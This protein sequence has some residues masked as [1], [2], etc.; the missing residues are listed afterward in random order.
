MYRTMT[1]LLILLAPCP[2]LAQG[3]EI[4]PD[5]WQ[6]YEAR[7]ALLGDSVLGPLNLGVKVRNRVAVLWGPV[8]SVEI[9]NQA[10]SLL[11][12]L[13]GLVA[14]K[15][16]LDVDPDLLLPLYL[17]ETL[18]QSRRSPMKPGTPPPA[19]TLTNRSLDKTVAQEKPMAAAFPP[20]AVPP[21]TIPGMPDHRE[22]EMVLPSLRIPTAEPE[23]S[24]TPAEAIAELQKD[25][26]FAHIQ[27]SITAGIVTL[28]ADADQAPLLYEFA[29]R[30]SPIPGVARVVVQEK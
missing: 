29:R 4:P 12:K 1:C 19:A 26:R 8:P 23:T 2:L 27:V 5:V 22:I 15:N 21:T 18:P 24:K 17:P 9:A 3:W 25:N 16:E 30:I 11:Q 13:P 14:V 6:T 20:V 7:K 28:S 10:V